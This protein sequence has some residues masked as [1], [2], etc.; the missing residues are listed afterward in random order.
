M[1][2]TKKMLEVMQLMYDAELADNLEDAEIVCDGRSC[3]LG[4]ERVP[5]KTVDGL[6]CFVAISLEEMGTQVERYTL[7][8]TGRML[9]I[10]P[11]RA[12]EVQIA[13]MNGIAYPHAEA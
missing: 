8:E 13:T 7:N 9:L 3:W 4:L 1:P 5:R 11:D 10:S 12:D 6:L 2:L